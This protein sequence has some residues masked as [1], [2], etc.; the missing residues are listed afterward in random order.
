MN[1]NNRVVRCEA[2]EGVGSYR[3]PCMAPGEARIA[4]LRLCSRHA[5]IFR[6]SGLID[7]THGVVRT[8]DAPPV[9]PTVPAVG[10]V[11]QIHPDVSPDFGGCFG[12]VAEVRAENRVYVHVYTI[13]QGTQPG[14]LGLDLPADAVAPIGPSQW[15]LKVETGPAPN[16]ETT[17]VPWA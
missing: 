2:V 16:G 7:T 12:V 17:D 3:V 9:A 10:W 14:V 1:A 11:V 6:A 8:E 15:I 5:A 13:Q 4:G